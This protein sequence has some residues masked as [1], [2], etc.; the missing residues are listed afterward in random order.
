MTRWQQTDNLAMRSAYDSLRQQVGFL[1][2][3]GRPRFTDAAKAA[4]YECAA[5]L[6]ELTRQMDAGQKG[7]GIPFDDA[8]HIM[9]RMCV[10][11]CVLVMSG[12]LDRIEPEGEE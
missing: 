10:A 5:Q 7:R 12:R 3:Q 9:V 11:G 2:M 6:G 4:M 8:M 1:G